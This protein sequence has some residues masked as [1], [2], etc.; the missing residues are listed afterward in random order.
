LVR[1]FPLTSLL[2]IASSYRPQLVA[3]WV[4]TP[5]SPTPFEAINESNR[6]F[7][8]LRCKYISAFIE[9]MYLIKRKGPLESLIKWSYAAPR[10]LPSFYDLSL[11]WALGCTNALHQAHSKDDLLAST[12]GLIFFA[13]KF[14]NAALCRISMEATSNFNSRDCSIDQKKLAIRGFLNVYKCFLRLNRPIYNILWQSQQMRH[15]LCSGSVLEADALCDAFQR[16]YGNFEDVVPISQMSW[17]EKMTIL[18]SATVKGQEMSE[19]TEADLDAIKRDRK[20]RKII[21]M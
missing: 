19:A 20:K 12:S 15:H 10:D 11:K 18:Q 8:R 17:E 7:D 4:T 5:A 21:D 2:N 13:K 9:C 1:K 14:A 16:V 6:K 3:V